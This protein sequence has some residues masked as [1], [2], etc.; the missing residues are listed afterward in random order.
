MVIF[1]LVFSHPRKPAINT[2]G[3][4]TLVL[5]SRFVWVSTTLKWK[6]KLDRNKAD[7]IVIL[8][9]CDIVSSEGGKWTA[10]NITEKNAH[11]H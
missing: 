11:D 10:F 7:K 6:T 2:D 5:L 9:K 4:G 1:V 3:F 8:Q